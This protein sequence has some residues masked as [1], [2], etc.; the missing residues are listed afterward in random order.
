MTAVLAKYRELT[1]EVMNPKRRESL[2][3]IKL[4]TRL[5]KLYPNQFVFIIPNRRDGT[6]VALNDIEHYL[7]SSIKTAQKEK[8]KSV[9]VFYSFIE[10]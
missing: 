7:R 2:C 9:E 5:E 3:R 1:E 8:E 6:F 10:N 4:R